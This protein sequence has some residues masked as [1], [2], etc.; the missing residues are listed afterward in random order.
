MAFD[1]EDVERAESR[2]WRRW[3]L[4]KRL[5]TVQEFLAAEIAAYEYSC[6]GESRKAGLLQREFRYE[7]DE[8]RRSRGHQ[9]VRQVSPPET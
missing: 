2:F 7:R 3:S 1:P 5:R 9:P 6:T 8:A 4:D